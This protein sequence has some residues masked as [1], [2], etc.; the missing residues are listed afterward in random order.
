MKKI[1][2]IVATL[3]LSLFFVSCNK[4]GQ[5]TPKNKIDRVCYSS[6]GKYEE[7]QNGY[8]TTTGSYSTDKYV[9]EIWNWDGKLLKSISYYTTDGNL[10]YTENY[11]YDGKRLVSVSWGTAGRLSL[12]YDGAKISSIEAYDGTV[13]SAEW[14]ITHT[15]SKISNIKI[16]EFENKRGTI[17][18]FPINMCRFFIPAPSVETFVEMLGRAQQHNMNTK[19][20]YSYDLELEWDGD[21]VKTIK[22][23]DGVYTETQEYTYDDKI[24]PYCGLFDLSEFGTNE[25]LSKNN[26][27]RMTYLDSDNDYG[28]ANYV[29][30]YDKK[31]PTMRSYSRVYTYDDERSSYTDNTYYE[32][33]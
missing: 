15:G 13:K 17:N 8:W 24:N 26:V 31:L 2:L 11:E 3:A 5:Y 25:V 32:Y 4:E 21:N 7:Y 18:S 6:T 20:I 28:E 9:G 27:T 14:T 16:T 33:K 10:S 23:I 22:F 29:Y 30:T 19:E 12:N 1:T